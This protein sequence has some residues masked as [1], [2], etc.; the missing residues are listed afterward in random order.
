MVEL[1]LVPVK[2]K[3]PEP[4][5]RINSLSF[6]GSSSYS[7]KELETL[8]ECCDAELFLM[9]DGD[10]DVGFSLV[11]PGKDVAYILLIAIDPQYR[12][13]GY[14]SAALNAILSRY[15][16]MPV[17]LDCESELRSFYERNGFFDTG[18]AFLY[19]GTIYHF[20]ASAEVDFDRCRYVVDKLSVIEDT[21][22]WLIR[23][24]GSRVLM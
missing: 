6:S 17:T 5:S 23:P 18:Y 7:D 16:G 19:K 10:S 1:F 2:G 22:T 8:M 21:E 13:K 15:D 12:S 11:L 24:D 14:G 4:V 3:V 9:R 20:M